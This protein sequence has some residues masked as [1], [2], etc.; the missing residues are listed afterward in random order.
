MSPTT[1]LALANA[2]A[3]EAQIVA[4]AASSVDLAYLRNIAGKLSEAMAAL[5]REINAPVVTNV[6]PLEGMLVLD[7]PKARFPN[8]ICSNCGQAF[9]P[10]DSGFSHC[11]S[12]RHLRALSWNEERAIE[13]REVA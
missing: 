9:G 8:V 4:H 3:A 1:R 5:E 11:Q 6:E 12:H 2:R 7:L 10:G 13:Q